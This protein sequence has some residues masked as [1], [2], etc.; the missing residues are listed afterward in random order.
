MLNN[1]KSFGLYFFIAFLTFVSCTS[2]PVFK[3]DEMG[4]EKSSI[5]GKIQLSDGAS[6]EGIYVWFEGLD[7]DTY[8]DDS[9]EF[10][11]IRPHPEEQPQG[12]LTGSYN[13]YYYIGNYKYTSSKVILRKGYFVNGQAD[14]NDK[15]EIGGTVILKKLLNIK[16]TIDPPVLAPSQIVDE[17][18][19]TVEATPLSEPVTIE[20]YEDYRSL[21]SFLL[22][23]KNKHIEASIPI[24]SGQG[25]KATKTINNPTTWNILF[26]T[27][28]DSAGFYEIIPYIKVIQEDLPETILENLSDNPDVYWKDY[29]K[30]PYRR[31]GG[32]LRFLIS[33]ISGR[34]TL[35]D[36]SSAMNTSVW[37][38]ALKVFVR[39]S[40]SG[41]YRLQ[42][43]PPELQPGGGLTGFY[44]LYFYRGNYRLGSTAIDLEEGSF[45][46]YES[47]DIELTKLL[48][49]ETTVTPIKI[50]YGKNTNLNIR[51]KLTPEDG[52]VIIKTFQDVNGN[53]AGFTKLNDPLVAQTIASGEP[54]EY[55][56]V[57]E[58]IVGIEERIMVFN[59]TSELHLGMHSVIPYIDVIQ[60]NI[61][62]DL[63]DFFGEKARRLSVS[64]LGIP[65]TRIVGWFAV[66]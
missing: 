18:T 41:N 35:N 34:V 8:T 3:D 9:G 22:R 28:K 12:G 5:T 54:D 37:L 51:I 29:L 23:R 45:K 36:E 20:V 62:P 2:N 48:S 6:P 59:K 39:T 33:S 15:G 10:K 52:P 24:F 65:Y 66:L 47:V 19:I 21:T 14:L 16:T 1:K 13:V 57:I 60:D 61:P 40:S 53:L 64:Y 43:P 27:A 44:S 31:E 56:E 50:N 7:V 25:I 49:I 11:L 32:N 30:V 55:M 17:V 38:D 26:Y 4:A 58:E 46:A 42:I 63:Y